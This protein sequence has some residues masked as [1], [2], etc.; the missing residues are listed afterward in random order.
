MITP[1][2]RAQN[3]Y[4]DLRFIESQSYIADPNLYKMLR[5]VKFQR[6]VSDV[7]RNFFFQFMKPQADLHGIWLIMDVD[8]C[9][10]YDDIP[11]YNIAKE[12][13]GGNVESNLKA[14]MEACDIVTVSTKILAGYYAARFDI[15]LSKFQVIPNYLPRWWIGDA[16]RLNESVYNFKEGLKTKLKI[17]FICGGN[18]YD[19]IN[20]NNGDDDFTHIIDW[21]KSSVD[22]YDFRFVG[23]IPQQLRQE[24]IDK[25]IILEPMSDVLNYPR[26]LKER[27]YNL[28]ICPL[29]DNVFNRCKS[30]IKLLE[31]WALGIPVFV[32]DNECYK[33][34][35][36]NVFRDGNDIENMISSLRNSEKKLVDEI[37]IGKQVVDF[38]D[39]NA[40]NGWWL[41]NN[42]SVHRYIYSLPQR[43]MKI[44]LMNRFAKEREGN[45]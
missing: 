19:L 14:V 24:Y 25:K 6:P 8:D 43:T 17:G 39:H 20:A 33:T 5:T 37:K 27:N 40:P 15:P 32:Q 3:V 45:L 4:D 7:A 29:K 21:I 35:T 1:K 34:Y 18:H 11:N 23:G 42:M 38:G 31:A 28:W 9:L 12:S 13:F 2:M 16:Y 30:N 26:V 36:P 44:N 10:C 22:V 41:E